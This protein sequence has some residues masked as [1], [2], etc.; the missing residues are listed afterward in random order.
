VLTVGI[1][2]WNRAG[3]LRDAIRS[4]V[5]QAD[6]DG[7]SGEVE[8]VVCDNASD[9]ETPRAVAEIAA[10]AR[11]PVRYHRA[12]EN[13]G[14]VVNALWTMELAGGEFFM[15]L[16]DDD[17]LVAGAVRGIV[18]ALR[19]EE[20]CEVM[21]FR[22]E[23][24][25]PQLD[26]TERLELDAEEGA[27]RFFYYAGNAGVFA[28]R[29]GP[30]QR[31]LARTGGR[32]AFSTCW[33]QTQVMFAVLAEAAHPRPLRAVP[34]RSASSPHHGEH[35]V[36]SSLYL[37]ETAVDAL[38]RTALELEPT[39]GSRW[40]RAATD[41]IFAWPRLRRI[42]TAMALISAIQE[43][44]PDAR[45]TRAEVGKRL[46]SLP[47]R[48]AWEV[49]GIWALLAVPPAAK[50]RLLAGLMRVRHPR[51]APEVIAG[52][53]EQRAR[54]LARQAASNTAEQPLRDYTKTGF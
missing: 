2:T 14:G 21:L 36:Y 47:P 53:R 37:W 52:W 24:P 9:D 46:R 51:S 43:S 25:H 10:A 28:V 31:V 15:L 20:G 44:A 3:V 22:Q 32:T 45:R 34:V 6:R 29:T 16:G 26:F 27:R 35:T 49:A 33:P 8:V 19:A 39:N 30:A 7:L 38:Y 17:V 50:R 12:A 5:D 1:P 23:P 11:T 13:A 18:E 54:Y 48:Y 40:V 42:G 41:H 4:V